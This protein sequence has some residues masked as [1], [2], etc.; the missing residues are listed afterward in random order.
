MEGTETLELVNGGQVHK[1][2]SKDLIHVEASILKHHMIPGQDGAQAELAGQDVAHVDGRTQQM[3]L[4]RQRFMMDGEMRCSECRKFVE[5]LVDL[6]FCDWCD[7]VYHR[8]C[9]SPESQ[10]NPDSYWICP[11]CESLY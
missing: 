7:R 8:T 10:A 3:L 5:D 2:S 11:P 1:K 4:Q 9:V 6:L